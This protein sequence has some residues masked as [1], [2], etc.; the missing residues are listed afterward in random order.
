MSFS[1]FIAFI[2][3][4]FQSS[5]TKLE[6]QI[7]EGTP[8]STHQLITEKILATAHLYL[9]LR[10][11]KGKNRSPEIDALILAN[12]GSLGEPYCVYGIQDV[13]QKV[14]KA[15]NL[16]SALFRT[17][18]TQALWNTTPAKYKAVFPQAGYIGIFRSRTDADHGHA[19]ICLSDLGIDHESFGTIEFNTNGLG[20]RDGDGVYMRTRSMKGTDHLELRGFIKWPEMFT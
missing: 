20:S 1:G 14:C 6:A 16:H 5:A 13:N 2:K 19:V 4:L 8:K 10:E 7:V 12:G 18:G 11:T 3:S 9:A 17:G 15:M